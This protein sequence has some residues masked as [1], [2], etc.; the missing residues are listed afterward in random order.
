MADYGKALISKI[1]DENDVLKATRQGIKPVWFEDADQAKVYEWILSHFERYGVVPSEVELKQQ[2]PNFR[3]SNV[4]E[5]FEYYIDQFRAQH[6]RSILVDTVIAA[7]EA[8][9]DGDLKTAQN[10]LSKGVLRIGKEVNVLTDINII[11]RPAREESLEGYRYAKEHA[12]ELTGIST[13]FDAFNF[14]TGGFHPQ[15]FVVLGGIAK[16]GKT[17]MLMKSAIAAHDAGC[18]V[19]FVSFEMSIKEQAARYHAMT[20]GIDASAILRGT[21]TDDDLDKIDKVMR[22]RRNLQPFVISADT[23]ATTTVSGLAAKIVEHQPDIVFIDGVYLMENEIG[24]DA[25]TTQAYTAISRSIKRL[26]QRT[27]LPVITTVQAL[28]GK[29]GKD[30]KVTINSFGWTSAWSQDADLLLAV[31]RVPDSDI[32][33][34]RIVAGRNASPMEFGVHFHWSESRIEE[35]DPDDEYGEAEDDG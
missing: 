5:P 1:I 23:S 30:A 26:A 16:Q 9:E 13:G 15:Q 17:F 14:V 35:I 6:K 24:A 11:S 3:L 25:G 8:L 12:G 28:P 10:E 22:S 4:L 20:A 31:E 34:M 21:A 2:F 7:N 27:N 19:L 29:I 33:K 18:C 32:F